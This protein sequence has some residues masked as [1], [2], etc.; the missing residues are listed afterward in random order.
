MNNWT[1]PSTMGG[2][3]MCGATKVS[4]WAAGATGTELVSFFAGNV[5]YS[6]SLPNQTLRTTWTQYTMTLG[7]MPDSNVSVGFGWT[8]VEPTV[9]GGAGVADATAPDAG[10]GATDAG[11]T[12][13]AVG[14]TVK[15]MIDNIQWQ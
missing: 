10:A 15:F 6:A 8:T 4:F 13:A 2:L 3:N 12:D 9:D 11:A 7:G 5:G 14:P 1:D